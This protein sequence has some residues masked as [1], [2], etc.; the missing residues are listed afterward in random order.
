[1][2]KRELEVFGGQC[3]MNFGTHLTVTSSAGVLGT[4]Q[5][6]PRHSEHNM[7]EG[8][9]K[10]T[11]QSYSKLRSIVSQCTGYS[12]SIT[13]IFSVCMH[14]SCSVAAITRLVVIVDL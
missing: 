11:S 14:A 4:E 3:A 12:S 7:E 5:R 6:R 10:Y 9:G 2:L 13:C 8:S 1:M